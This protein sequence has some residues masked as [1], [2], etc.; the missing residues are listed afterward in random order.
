MVIMT[1]LKK[2]KNNNNKSDIYDLDGECVCVYVC[3]C[4]L[5]GVLFCSLSTKK[6]N[7]YASYTRI[8]SSPLKF[9]EKEEE[10]KKT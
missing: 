10:E 3:V 2:K 5:Q 7:L 9:L 4:A 1:Q 8:L 6:N